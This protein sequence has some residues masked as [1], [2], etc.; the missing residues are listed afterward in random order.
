[1]TTAS[2]D[3]IG[4]LRA[5]GDFAHVFGYH[6]FN[7]ELADAHGIWLQDTAG[8]RYIDASGGPMAVNIGHG[9]PRMKAAI[10]AQLD[11][12]AYCHPRHCQSK[13]TGWRSRGVYVSNGVCPALEIKPA[14]FAISTLLRKSSV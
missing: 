7:I 3:L 10:A 11:H 5:E 1:M 2:D 14:R 13:C 6:P 9:D 4:M 12:F 8:R